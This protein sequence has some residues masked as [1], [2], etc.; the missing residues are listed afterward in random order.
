VTAPQP[1]PGGTRWLVTITA[2]AEVIR[3]G[4]GAPDPE[5]PARP[6]ESSDT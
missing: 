5:E 3:G 1:A 2:E 4:A 6:A